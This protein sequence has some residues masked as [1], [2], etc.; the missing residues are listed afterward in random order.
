MTAWLYRLHDADGQ[1]LYIGCTATSVKQRTDAHRRKAWGS[2]IAEVSTERYVDHNVALI[3]ERTA[4]AAEQ[5]FYNKGPGGSVSGPRGK[6]L[7]WQLA[8][9]ALQ[10]RDH[11]DLATWLTDQRGSDDDRLSYSIIAFNLSTW[12]DHK[13]QVTPQTIRNWINSIKE[14]A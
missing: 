1:L 13:V 8:D 4:I 7:H 2:Q 9:E 10:R 5:P 12:T 11:G 3:A 14:D 6:S